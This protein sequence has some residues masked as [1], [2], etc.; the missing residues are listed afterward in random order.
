[1]SGD[2]VYFSSSIRKVYIHAGYKRSDG[3][4]H[5][6][7]LPMTIDVTIEAMIEEACKYD[8]PGHKLV[9]V[10]IPI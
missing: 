3:E 9:S 10:C 6:L 5:V 2:E 4:P 8:A 7:I 1:M